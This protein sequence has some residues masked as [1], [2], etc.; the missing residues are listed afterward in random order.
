MAFNGR[1]TEA[2]VRIDGLIVG[3]C[4][5]GFIELL[6]RERQGLPL[7]LGPLQDISFEVKPPEFVRPFPPTIFKGFN[8][9]KGHT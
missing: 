9:G 1:I 3:I 2:K 5:M 8:V 4:A 7:T 6:E